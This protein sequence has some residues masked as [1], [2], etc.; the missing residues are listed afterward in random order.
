MFIRLRRTSRITLALRGALHRRRLSGCL[1]EL[2]ADHGL[3]RLVFVVLVPQHL[4]L[5]ELRIAIP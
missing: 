4:L 3:A 2:A 5:L 1:L